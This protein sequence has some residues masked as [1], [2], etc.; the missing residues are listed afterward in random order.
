MLLGLLLLDGTV[1]YCIVIVFIP[2]KY[3]CVAHIAVLHD[4]FTDY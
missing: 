3:E 2:Y 4:Y 1:L